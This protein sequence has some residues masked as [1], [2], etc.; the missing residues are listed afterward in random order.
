MAIIKARELEYLNNLIHAGRESSIVD[1]KSEWYRFEY[2]NSRFEFIKDCISFLNSGMDADKYIIIG[3]MEDKE[4]GELVPNRIDMHPEES[5][6]QEI[7]TSYIE[8]IPQIDILMRVN[9]GEYEADVIKIRKENRDLPY[10]FRKDFEGKQTPDP[11]N[12][13]MFKKSC[14]GLGYIRHG[15][16]T[17]LI[18]RNELTNMFFRKQGNIYGYFDLSAEINREYFSDIMVFLDGMNLL[19]RREALDSISAVSPISDINS[20]SYF[21]N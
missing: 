2:A 9:L 19:V 16:S 20:T 18:S 17:D 15:S 1:F 12:V 6:I 13:K 14:R 10:L 5:N 3:F 8:P 4:R 7:I 21:N 11:Q